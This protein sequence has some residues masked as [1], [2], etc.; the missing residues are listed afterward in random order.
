M[1]LKVSANEGLDEF[2]ERCMRLAR[3]FHHE[4]GRHSLETRIKSGCEEDFVGICA[5]AKVDH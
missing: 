4:E 5:D 3:I 2:K 1:D